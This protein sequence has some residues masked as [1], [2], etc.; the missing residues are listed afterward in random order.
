MALK[1]PQQGLAMTDPVMRAYLDDLLAATQGSTPNTFTTFTGDSGT[2]TASSPTDTLQIAGGEGID[3]AVSGDVVTI[4]GEDATTANKGIA[5]FNST[6]FSVTAGEVSLV[7]SATEFTTI[8]LGNPTDTTLARLSAGDVTIEGNVIYRAGG[9]DVAVADGGT[10]ASTASAA[11]DN[12][13]LG[14][15]NTPQFT[16]IEVGAASDTTL[17]RSGAG[18]IAVEGK[19]IYRADGTDVPVADGGTGR[20]SHTAY[21]VICGGTAGTTAQQSIASVGTTNF[22]LISNGA[23]ALPTFQDFWG[24]AVTSDIVPSASVTRSLGSTSNR[25]LK[26]WTRHITAGASGILDFSAAQDL[27]VP[28][29]SANLSGQGEVCVASVAGQQPPFQYHDGAGARCNISVTTTKYTSPT[30]ASV[31]VYISASSDFDLQAGATLRTTLGVQASDATLTALAAYNTNGLLA[32]TAADTFA[33]R[34][35]TAG[36]G[37]SVSNGDGVS[38]NPTISLASGTIV[39]RVSNTSTTRGQSTT[40]LP[41]DGTIPQNTEGDEFLTVAITPKNSSNILR[42]TVTSGLIDSSGAI[43][44]CGALF[45]DTTANALTAVGYNIQAAARYETMALHYQMTA[46]TTSSTTFKFRYGPA[47]A[48][49]ATINGSNGSATPFGSAKIMTI[50]EVIE[51]VA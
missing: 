8:E 45:Q 48:G 32:Q 18:D 26:L 12:L 44:W 42:I 39:Q 34:T 16:G 17:T 27:I 31:P 24:L 50:I 46:G 43:A 51:Q 21:A 23:G 3:T 4:S 47:S 33:G 36:N 19:A 22:A 28:T 41:I 14:T 37:I 30:T 49:T 13:G 10:G 11:R 9:T 7:T 29:S 5:S 35:V 25:F 20:S 2:T 40:V 38:G 6:Y 15:G 1:P